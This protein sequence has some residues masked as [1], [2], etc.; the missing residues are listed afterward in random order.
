MKNLISNNESI[1]S[2]NL[3]AFREESTEL[4]GARSE[5]QSASSRC[6]A[7]C[8][9]EKARAL[10][11]YD[12]AVKL[13]C[14][15]IAV[16]I[17][18][19]QQTLS[20]VVPFDISPEDMRA[21]RFASSAELLVDYAERETIT[22][23]IFLAYHHR[24]EFVLDAISTA[25]NIRPKLVHGKVESILAATVKEPVPDLLNKLLDQA[26]CAQASDIH[27][28][29]TPE[30]YRLR[31]REDGVLV[32]QKSFALSREVAAA[33][34][35]RIRVLANLDVTK[36][37]T[38]QEGGFLYEHQPWSIRVRLSIV[39]LHNG[40]KV[41]L[42][43]L[44]NNCFS[45]PPNSSANKGLTT[46]GLSNDQAQI[47]RM[48]LASG[49]GTLLFVGPTGSGKSTLLYSCLELL[50]KEVLNICTIEDPV[51]RLIAGAAQAEI[52]RTAGRDYGA[53]LRDLLRQD[54]DVVM[55]GEIRDKD[56]ADTA[57]SAGL[58]GHLV[59]STLHAGNCVE[60]I[61]RLFQLKVN[62]ELIVSSLKLI[63]AQRLIRKNCNY[64]RK[65]VSLS[66][67]LRLFLGLGEEEAVYQGVGCPYCKGRG[68]LG[69]TGIYEFLPMARPLQDYL[70]TAKNS[71]AIS[72]SG[73]QEV[74]KNCAYRP[75]IFPLQNLI[76]AGVISPYLALE[77]LGLSAEFFD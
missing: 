14:L 73:L 67:A 33:L 54:P 2:D 26:L 61:F 4:V 46:L 15:P 16:V 69:R 29:P 47:L 75:F 7:L 24:A 58:T 25:E 23:A 74:A 1:L 13:A 70:L 57:L 62:S 17:S 53:L 48:A 72:V 21:L 6:L 44:D 37:N 10:I 27:I 49:S 9:T 59:L 71:G 22:K 68:Y 18:Q 34:F 19:E 65:P 52:D 3:V 40:E 41:V 63:I 31:F 30:N 42:R 8:S 51:E 77:V 20:V 55:L 39:P 5:A 28:E 76:S 56:V 60:S 32:E 36:A 64:C 11:D 12:N 38:S 43:L 50:N 66:P 45:L 35:R